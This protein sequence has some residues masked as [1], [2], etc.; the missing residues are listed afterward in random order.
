MIRGRHASQTISDA[1]VNL[2]TSRSIFKLPP[3][4]KFSRFVADKSRRRRVQ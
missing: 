1:L 2:A 3:A 4:V